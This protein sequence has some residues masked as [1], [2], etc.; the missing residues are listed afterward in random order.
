[1]MKLTFL[2]LP[3]WIILSILFAPL[4]MAAPVNDNLTAAIDITNLPYTHQQS[5]I[6]ASNEPAELLSK[7]FNDLTT[8]FVS[9]S[10]WYKYTATRN[11][12]VTYDTLGSDYDTLL[13]VWQGTRHPLTEVACNDDNGN[14]I[15]SHLS[16][17]LKKGVTYYINV[18]GF[19]G[20]SGNLIL[21]SRSVGSLIN[22]DLADA[23]EITPDADFAYSNAQKTLDATD[24]SKELVAS[25]G[26]KSQGSIWYQYTA[27]ESQRVVFDTVSS[28]YNTIL[29]VWAGNQHPLKEIVC[30]D[31]DGGPDSRVSVEITNGTTYYISVATGKVGGGSLLPR[32]G[33]L[34]M[35]MSA[36]PPNDNMANALLIEGPLPYLNGQNTGGATEESEERSP[37]CSPNAIASVWYLYTPRVDYDNVVFSTVGS[38]YDTVLSLWQGTDYPLTELACNDDVAVL[39]QE[40]TQLGSASQISRPVTQDETIYIDVG[41]AD[42]E[43]GNLILRVE[44]GK[45]DF[46][47]TSYPT[48]SLTSCQKST[49]AVVDPKHFSKSA[50]ALN[51]KISTTGKAIEISEPLSY[52]W[53][54]GKSSDSSTPV[55]TESDFT[56]PPLEEDTKY[57]V[58]IANPTGTLDSETITVTVNEPTHANGIGVDAQGSEIANKAN[59]TGQITR[60]STGVSGNN[61]SLRRTDEVS[62]AFTVA[63][64]SKHFSESADVLAVARY[65]TEFSDKF[66][67]RDNNLWEV[68]E[69]VGTASGLSNLTAAQTDISLQNC[70]EVMVYEDSLKYLFGQLTIY[71]GY[72]LTDT[73][74]VFYNG[75]TINFTVE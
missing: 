40:V 2:H 29:A 49:L 30:H 38:S 17:S 65:V 57:W 48:P 15:Q 55:S 71:V 16:L 28:D 37:S 64:D 34:V 4:G 35:N 41:S 32:T 18:S 75:E 39:T 13:S 50:D 3:V 19:R 22:D 12:K 8:Q 25:C 21:N 45:T 46:E 20:V 73:G 11:K 10:V 70:L 1:M 69:D 36:P 74:E 54:Q 42:G 23:I 72:R 7:C 59:F 27:D 68:W 63:V 56:T 44:E 60:L 51:V 61:L 31:G 53:Y 6:E 47:I 9:A 66:F 62:I 43:T 52:Q 24:E 58:H 14:Q 5:T 26:A 33:L 67:M